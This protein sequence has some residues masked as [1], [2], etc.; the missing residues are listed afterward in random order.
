MKTL[1]ERKILRLICIVKT[2]E[3]EIREEV[4]NDLDEVMSDD[5]NIQAPI[6][7]VNILLGWKDLI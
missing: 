1:L 4:V 7:L 2:I 5:C 6:I 3:E